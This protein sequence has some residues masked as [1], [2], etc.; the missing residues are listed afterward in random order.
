MWL[1]SLA[2]D[3]RYVPRE[4]RG[5]PVSKGPVGRLDVAQVIK[6]QA[7]GCWLECHFRTRAGVQTVFLVYED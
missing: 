2:R 4:V 6:R 7:T 3:L 1:L 5:C